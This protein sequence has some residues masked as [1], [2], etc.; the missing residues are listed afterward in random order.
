M[1]LAG[2]GQR[3]VSFFFF[4]VVVVAPVSHV[5]VLQRRVGPVY[6]CQQ[7]VLNAHGDEVPPCQECGRPHVAGQVEELPHQSR[8]K[9][10]R[11]QLDAAQRRVHI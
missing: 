3:F 10:E 1:V 6:V 8:R 11:G 4:F 9:H 5:L 2:S 7:R